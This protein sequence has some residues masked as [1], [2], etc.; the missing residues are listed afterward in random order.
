MSLVFR[1]PKDLFHSLLLSWLGLADVGRLD[2]AICNT[3]LRMEFLISVTETDFVFSSFYEPVLEEGAENRLDS[4]LKWLTKRGIATTRLTVTNSRSIDFNEKLNYLRL[5]GKC[6]TEVFIS[7]GTPFRKPKVVMEDV[8]AWGPDILCWEDYNLAW[9]FGSV[10]HAGL[11]HIIAS[12]CPQ[13]RKL[14][15]SHR[16]T[17]GD[18]AALG[19]GCPLLTTVD[20]MAWAVTD[21]GL[22][23]IARNGALVNLNVKSRYDLTNE[24]LQTA[25]ALCPHLESVDLSACR[26]LTDATLIALGRHCR[27]LREMDIS[28]TQVTT[29]GL[30]AIAADCPLLEALSAGHCDVGSSIEAV[31]RSCPRL[32]VLDLTH[33]EVPAEAVLALAECCPLLDE[34]IVC[35]CWGVGDVE[36]TALVRGCPELTRLDITGTS[37][38]VLGLSAIRDHCKKLAR[39]A[40]YKELYYNEAFTVSFFPVGVK[41]VLGYL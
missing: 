25:A 35:G 4:F 10:K 26:Q 15:T 7:E 27:S 20:K 22:L 3:C 1:L 14:Y 12:N 37:V 17:D 32:R 39:I 8:A 31:A 28:F 34:V 19:E 11:I 23:A 29:T 38:T 18:L 21:A 41:V 33:V 16:L 5:N 40:L 9:G 13:L 24:G 2:S 6:V 36:V 30:R